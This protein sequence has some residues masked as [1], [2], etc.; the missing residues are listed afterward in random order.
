MSTVDVITSYSIHYTKLY[1]VATAIGVTEE[2]ITVIP[3]PFVEMDNAEIQDAF[4]AQSELLSSMQ[5]ASTT[6]LLIT[7]AT[8]L[9]VLI[10]LFMIFRMFKKT[11]EPLPAEGGFEYIADEQIIPGEEQEHIMTMDDFKLEDFEKTD[12]T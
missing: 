2:R 12:N 6:R 10:F 9:V 8:V 4:D 7:L 1:E 11:A 5:S 3:L